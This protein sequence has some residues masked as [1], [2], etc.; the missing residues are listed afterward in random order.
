MGQA[1]LMPVLGPAGR[2]AGLGEAEIGLIVSVS[3]VAAVVAAPWWGR[4]SD[5]VGRRP[6]FLVGM[7][8]YVASTLAFAAVLAWS[9]NYSAQPLVV[10]MSL[11]AARI[12]YAGIASGV[13][14]AAAGFIADVSVPARRSAAMSLTG[15]AFGIGSIAGGVLV[16]ATSGRLGLLTPLWIT[17]ACAL[18]IFS[19]AAAYLRD[20]QTRK[21]QPIH[22]QISSLSGRDPRI[23][24]ILA[25]VSLAFLS[26]SMVQQAVPFLVQDR[27]ALN[28]A[29][30]ATQAAFLAAIMAAATLAGLFAAIRLSSVPSQT[31][32]VG[33][34]AVS[35]GTVLLIPAA[36]T[37]LLVMSHVLMGLGFGLFVPAAQGLASLSVGPR[38]QATVAAYLSAAT[39]MGYI[40]GPTLAGVLYEIGP[41]VVLCI[42]TVAAIAGA[43]VWI[44]QR[45][46]LSVAASDS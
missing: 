45:G 38:E 19:I 23:R 21:E 20:P 36:G 10:F 9:Q 25:V 34:V 5:M 16:F 2:A 6:V 28:T 46:G 42:A 32:G 18:L 44:S 11:L 17:S 3:A 35:V 22:P 8:G 1:V 27:G 4:R 12:A 33:L 29:E 41:T 24:C 37:A 43:A 14:P 31:A 40:A 26:T 15:I 39:T 30:A 13:A 7:A